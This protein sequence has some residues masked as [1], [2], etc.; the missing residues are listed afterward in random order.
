MVLARISPGIFLFRGTVLP[1]SER[2]K[3]DS[4]VSAEIFRNNTTSNFSYLQSIESVVLRL[5]AL[6][7]QINSW[8]REALVPM[9]YKCLKGT[10][11]EAF[12]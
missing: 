3:S 11:S 4:F 7:L 12:G 8:Y 6:R 9:L 10:K 5:L 1:S 2:L